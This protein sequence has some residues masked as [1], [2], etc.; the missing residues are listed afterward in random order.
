M[1]VGDTHERRQGEEGERDAAMPLLFSLGQHGALKAV[2][3]G[4]EEG[5][6]LL[7][8]WTICA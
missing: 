7:H 1:T 6:R 3:R 4:L 5:E 2:A 8:F